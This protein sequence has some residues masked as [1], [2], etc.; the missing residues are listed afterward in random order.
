M[1]GRRKLVL[2]TGSILLLILTWLVWDFSLWTESKRVNGLP[3]AVVVAALVLG[4]AMVFPAFTYATL[5]IGDNE[6][7]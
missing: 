6:L 3:A 4:T 2:A 5:R 7:S 1:S